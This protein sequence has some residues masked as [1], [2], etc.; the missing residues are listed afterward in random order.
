MKAWIVVLTVVGTAMQVAALLRYLR[1]AGASL[2]RR[3]AIARERGHS[4]TTWDDFDAEHGGD[5]LEP[6]RRARDDYRMDVALIGGGGLLL[7]IAS[8]W[9]LYV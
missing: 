5:T 1:R 2:A 4:E 6:L 3:E 9:S 8:I 7:L